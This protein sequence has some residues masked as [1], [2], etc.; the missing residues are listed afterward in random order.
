MY[1]TNFPA[2]A[3]YGKLMQPRPTLLPMPTIRLISGQLARTAA[4]YYP[5]GARQSV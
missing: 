3:S 4:D 2:T 5:S 1:V